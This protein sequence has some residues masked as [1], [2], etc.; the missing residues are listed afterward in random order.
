MINIEHYT[1]RVSWSAADGEF[2]ATCAELPSLSWLAG[3]LPGRRSE[4]SDPGGRGRRPRPAGPA[5]RAGRCRRRA[6]RQPQPVGQRPSGT[7][8][9]SSSHRYAAAGCISEGFPKRSRAE[10]MATVWPLRI[11]GTR[12]AAQLRIRGCAWFLGRP[13]CWLGRPGRAV[14]PPAP[15]ARPPGPPGTRYASAGGG[16]DLCHSALTGRALMR[17]PSENERGPVCH[18]EPA[19]KRSPGWARRRRAR[20]GRCLA[21]AQRAC[22]AATVRSRPR[23]RDTR[24]AA[25]AA[26]RTVPAP[27]R[28][29]WLRRGLAVT[30]R[31]RQ[32]L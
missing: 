3:W 14:L 6:G 11:P 15:P 17:S 23:E 31:S 4:G 22:A 16:R 30:R 26:S 10:P 9:T 2:V 8:L 27:W 5:P 13:T 12:V 32:A 29:T 24:P 25:C 1:Y 7:D 28:L 21:D 18:T 20:R 19:A